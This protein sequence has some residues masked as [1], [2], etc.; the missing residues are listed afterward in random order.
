MQAI[1]DTIHTIRLKNV[2]NLMTKRGLRLADLARDLGKHRSQMSSLFG[3]KGDR[4]NCGAKMARQ[5]EEV[6]NL[7]PL[8]LDKPYGLDCIDDNTQLIDN[9]EYDNFSKPT[10]FT[11][12]S[13][14]A[15][16]NA[17]QNKL[18]RVTQQLNYEGLKVL[19][20]KL[21]LEN[22]DLWIASYDSS[23]LKV[24]NQEG[25][26]LLLNL[27]S[28]HPNLTQINMNSELFHLVIYSS[29]H[30]DTFYILPPDVWPKMSIKR[31]KY[32]EFRISQSVDDD[33]YCKIPNDL[34]PYCNNFK[35]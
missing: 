2:R 28:Y 1:Q 3:N 8:S 23:T 13:Y 20:Q 21:N 25:D 24:I 35:L 27:H 19:Q 9:L 10:F 29:F 6:Y 7:P 5:I 32:Y 12:S 4:K 16:I 33:L 30:E 34:Q 11:L 17:L 14:T 18:E 26:E 15:Q 31:G 22:R